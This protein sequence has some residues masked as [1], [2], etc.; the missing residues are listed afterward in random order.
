VVWSS[1][2]LMRPIPYPLFTSQHAAETF[3]KKLYHAW[4]EHW[5]NSEARMQG[6]SH[7]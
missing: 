6:A 1:E 4:G 5:T 3:M 7:E 2:Q